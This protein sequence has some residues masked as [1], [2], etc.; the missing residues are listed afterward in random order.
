MNSDA[1]NDLPVSSSSDCLESGKLS[2]TSEIISDV[3][4]F[5]LCSLCAIRLNQLYP[6]Q[7][8]E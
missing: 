2:R 1:T 5:S 6:E 8:H 4:S 3:V 7:H